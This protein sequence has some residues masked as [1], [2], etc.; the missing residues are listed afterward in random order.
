M[1]IT[2]ET[3]YALRIMRALSTGE[4]LTAREISRRELVPGQFT[5]KIIKK[6]ER[7][8]LVEITH[9]AGGGCRLA[10]NL[11]SVTIYDLMAALGVE[12]QVN[13]CTVPGYKCPWREE[14]G[15]DCA[16]HTRLQEI[17]GVLNNEL[18]SHSLSQI[19]YGK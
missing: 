6:L 7:A 18:R 10:T 1:L 19:L 16:V 12:T 14:F 13:L 15:T 3:D 2:R 11:N 17:Q 9:G 5:Y 8:L 4:K